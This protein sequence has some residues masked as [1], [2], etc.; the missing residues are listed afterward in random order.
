PGGSTPDWPLPRRII[1][2]G[3]N[4]YARMML[5]L[6]VRDATAGFRAFRTEA[7]R[8]LPYRQAQASG[9]GF[10]VEMAWRAHQNGLKIVEIPVSFR[11][12]TRGASKMGPG[13]VAEAMWLVTKWGI[14]R[15][16]GR[17]R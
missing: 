14:S 15:I 11:D 9:Y 17:R 16:F 13:I 10:Q 12:R 2:R 7:L 5:G 6:K 8:K 1:S 3:G 4:W